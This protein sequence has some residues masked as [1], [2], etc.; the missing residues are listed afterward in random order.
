MVGSK[1]RALLRATA[2]PGERSLLLQKGRFELI[3]PAF[4]RLR[5]QTMGDLGAK[6]GFYGEDPGY[7]GAGEVRSP[8]CTLPGLLR[9]RVPVHIRPGE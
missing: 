8:A 2:V 7:G 9:I 1:F 5:I 6:Y 3:S 4:V